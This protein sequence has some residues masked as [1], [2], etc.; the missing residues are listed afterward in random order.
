MLKMIVKLDIGFADIRFMFDLYCL[1]WIW[2]KGVV[3]C[4]LSVVV[5]VLIFLFGK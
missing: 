4:L 2:D 1:E 5:F 3:M